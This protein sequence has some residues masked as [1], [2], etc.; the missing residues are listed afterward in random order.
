MR[1]FSIIVLMGLAT[2]SRAEPRFHAGVDVGGIGR[3]HP[4]V[5]E[6][7]SGF[8][9]LRAGLELDLPSPRWRVGFETSWL[10]SDDVNT[11]SSLNVRLR[12]SYV[13]TQQWTASV[14]VGTFTCSMCAF[15][16]DP[17]FLV[18]A[19]L[20]YWDIGAFVE[21]RTIAYDAG[22]AFRP[23]GT[24]VT[25]AAGLSTNSR[26]SYRPAAALLGLVVFSWMLKDLNFAH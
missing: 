19:E 10:V 7:A 26:F 20:G 6:R 15:R 25:L 4:E 8:L 3:V 21:A 18:R 14:A 11:Q 16:R 2:P 13:S 1:A 24:E 17:H 5:A 23:Y 22:A 12:G 9:D